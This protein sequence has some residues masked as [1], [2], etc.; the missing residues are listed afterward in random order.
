MKINEIIRKMSFLQLV[1]LKSDEGAPLANKTKVKIIL[2]LVAY[3]RAMES[4]NEDMRGIY[5]RLKPEG[6]DAQAF[7][8]VNELEK[9][10]NISNEEKQELE[11]IKQ[12]EEYL[13]FVDMGKT[14]M[15][16]FEEARECASA[17]NDYTVSERALTDD[18]LV[19]I[20]EVIP[21]DKEFAIGRNEDG[22]IKVNGIAVLAEIGR[23]FIM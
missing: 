4:F 8:R 6:Y 22:E 1:P 10:E 15:R 14:L 19:S 18:D 9:K 13:S 21:S 5:A 20:A 11:S 16:E 2:N 23:M 12:S 17:D 7:P 3:E